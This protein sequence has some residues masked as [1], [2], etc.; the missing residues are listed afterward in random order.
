MDWLNKYQIFNR[1]INR[2]AP[3]LVVITFLM[4]LCTL[5]NNWKPEWDSAYYLIIAKSIISGHGFTYLGYPCLKIPFGFPLLISPV[6]SLTQGSFLELNL[7]MLFFAFFGFFM[8][9]FCFSKL[10]PGAYSFLI[11][12]LTAWS[13]LML[14]YS[15]FVMID[16]PYLAF[17]FAAMYFILTYMDKPVLVRGIIAVALILISYFLRKIG[18][19]LVAGTL[20]YLLLHKAHLI[21]SWKFVILSLMLL[22][23]VGGWALFTH[24]KKIDANDP[25]WQLIE[26]IPSKNEIQRVRYDDPV[27]SLNGPF[28]LVKRGIKNSVYY[29]G[30]SSSLMIGTP[31]N[32]KKEN[33]ELFPVWWLGILGIITLIIVLGFLQSLIRR[34]TLPDLYFLFYMA[35][36][37]AWS[38]R[39]PRYLLPVLPLLINYLINGMSFVIYMA[40]KILPV[41]QKKTAVLTVWCV[42][43]FCILY[44]SD[45]SLQNGKII[46]RQRAVN[47]YSNYA[48]SFFSVSSWLKENTPKEARVVSVLAPV[49]SMVSDRWCVSFPRIKDPNRIINFLKEIRGEYLIVCPAYGHEEDYLLMV[50]NS[51]PS[52]FQQI[53]NQGDAVIFKVNQEKIV[54]GGCIITTRNKM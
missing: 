52:C 29:A 13:Y 31:I 4:Y 24:G 3:F 39:E 34:K 16:V 19:V 28:D 53:Y 10:Y 44:M 12:I 36:L 51:Y 42:A 21:K 37:L 50:I 48:S 27:A 41:I 11:V 33:L 18:I 30:V 35:I 26:F 17:S 49:A 38:A 45:N 1:I 15:G 46:K 40:G 7:Y 8:I 47:F 25:V 43:G 32:P 22:I 6:V 14:D 9:Y 5:N 54:K 2:I 20:V 23:P